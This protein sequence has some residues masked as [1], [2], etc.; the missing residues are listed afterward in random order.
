MA[1]LKTV[2]Y[3][4][5]A[6]NHFIKHNVIHILASKVKYSQINGDLMFFA[7]S[8]IFFLIMWLNCKQ[9]GKNGVRSV[10]ITFILFKF[11]RSIDNFND[12]YLFILS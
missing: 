6:H 12:F 2:V 3:L 9:Y 5:K 1:L 7:N 4:V 8:S 11:H 10:K